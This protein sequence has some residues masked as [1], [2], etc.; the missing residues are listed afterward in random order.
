MTY[1]FR[2]PK[3][4]FPNDKTGNSKNQFFFFY[5]LK[6]IS[7]QSHL[8]K[9]I[10]KITGRNFSSS[11]IHFEGGRCFWNVVKKRRNHSLHLSRQEER[12]KALRALFSRQRFPLTKLP[13]LVRFPPGWEQHLLSFS[14]FFFFLFLLDCHSVPSCVVIYNLM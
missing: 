1:S 9:K 13:L 7:C 12:E 2:N 6:P 14:L 11:L 10:K 3:G 4:F 8:S 5:F